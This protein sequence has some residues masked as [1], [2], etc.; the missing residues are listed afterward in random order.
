MPGSPDGVWTMTDSPRSLDPKALLALL[1]HRYPFLLIDRVD[2][3]VP[4]TRIV[5]RKNVSW[6]EPYFQGH[7][8]GDPVMPGVLQVEAMAQAAAL[9]GLESRP[10]LRLPGAGVLLLG[11]DAVRFRRKV[12]PG[13][14]LRIEVS[15]DRVRGTTW[16]VIGQATVDGERAAEATILAA[17]VLPA[18]P[19]TPDGAR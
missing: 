4:D 9:L 11:L 15:V 7:F 6:N 5:A 8:P 12:V 16:R 18:Q 14:V 2:E 3:L 19:G 17:F 10:E 13:D 1:P